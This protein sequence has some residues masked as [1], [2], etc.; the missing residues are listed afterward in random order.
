M[1]SVR[2]AAADALPK[3]LTL[4]VGLPASGKTTLAKRMVAANVGWTPRSGLTHIAADEHRYVPGT[5]TKRPKEDFIRSVRAAIDAA[6]TPFCVVDTTY[7]DAHDPTAARVALVMDLLASGTVADLV[8]M[9]ST[10]LLVDLEKVMRR[11]LN[12]ASGAEPQGAAVETP[13]NVAAQAAKFVQ[14]YDA[15]VAALEDL[16]CGASFNVPTRYETACHTSADSK[17]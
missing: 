7:R 17:Q 16:A 6:P 1:E 2:S 14:Q 5:W 9:K 12:R 13:A 10:S 3:R 15:N 4:I 11:S 8:I